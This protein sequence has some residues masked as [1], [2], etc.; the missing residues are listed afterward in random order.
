[1]VNECEK[2]RAMCIEFKIDGAQNCSRM[3]MC[4]DFVIQVLKQKNRKGISKNLSSQDLGE[5]RVN[6]LA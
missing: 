2:K 4:I 1:M 3:C 6:F 5:V